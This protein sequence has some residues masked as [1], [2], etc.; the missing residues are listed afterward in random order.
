MVLAPC[1][2]SVADRDSLIA[3]LACPQCRSDLTSLAGC[4]RCGARF[5]ETDGIPVLIHPGASRK[6]SFEFQGRRSVVRDEFR[7][8]F[9][10]PPRNG[11]RSPYHLD[12]GHADVIESL[13]SPASILEIG[14]GG[15]QMRSYVEALGHR[16]IGVDI[17][18]TRVAD[19]LQ[20][21]GGPDLLCDSHFL[22][23]RA[24]M[25]DVV[26][27]AAV[28]EH[29]ACPYLVAQEVARVLVPG[30][31]YLGN[32][33]FLE[34]WHDDSFFHMTPLGVCELLTQAGLRIQIIW[35]GKGYSGFRAIM[36][37]SGRVTRLMAPLGDAIHLV[38]RCGNWVLRRAGARHT[39]IEDAAK[40]AGAVDWIARKPGD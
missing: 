32:V 18:K 7:A 12:Y 4:S 38:Y 15:G 13:T 21:H 25:F 28:T 33:S 2:T 40:V 31:R 39:S 37:M 36:R 1:P 24:D 22:P 3:L 11:P 9:R 14:C 34:P 16:Y 23:F 29:L 20:A 10:Y 5:V 17:S 35:P 6:V 8:A 27:S 26:Y 30:G 19:D